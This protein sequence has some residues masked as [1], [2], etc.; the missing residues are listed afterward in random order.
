M[1]DYIHQEIQNRQ[2]FGRFTIMF[3]FLRNWAVRKD[4]KTLLRLSDYQLRDIGLTRYELGRLIDL[5]SG[6]DLAWELE[7][8]GAKEEIRHPAETPNLEIQLNS[9]LGVESC[10]TC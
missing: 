10:T 8:T 5:P 2:A 3:R 9:P 4:L 7:R 1:R 6:C